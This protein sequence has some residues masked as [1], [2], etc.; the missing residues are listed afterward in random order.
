MSRPVRIGPAGSRCRLSAMR[1]LLLRIALTALLPVMGF[2]CAGI[3][4]QESAANGQQ[5]FA[6]LG[7]CKLATGQTIS[8]CRLG[9][10]T[11]GT[12]NADRSNAVLFPTWFSGTTENLA[13]LVGADKLVDPAKY[14]VI[15]VDALG[16]GVSSSPSNSAA[17]QG[18]DFP[19]F[20]TRDMVNAEYRLATEKLGLKHLHAVMGISMGGMQ[21]FEWMVNYPDFMDVAVPIVGSTRLTGYDLLLWHAEEDALKEN[22]AWH[23]GRYTKAPPMGEVE[24]IHAMN[25]RTPANYARTYPPETFAAEYAEYFSKGILPFDANDWLAQLEAMIHHDVAHGATLEDA[26]KRVKAKVL[27]VVAAQDHMVNPKPALDFAELIGAR[28]L[29]LES[30]CGHLSPGCELGKVS[31]AVRDFLDGR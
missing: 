5:Q 3:A 16:D 21:T 22:P 7:A 14:F 6:D 23:E 27:V 13:A 18:P 30:D 24:T 20:T 15:A 8:N 9:Y 2:C 19:A 12:L 11:W 25:L 31:A 29:V 17:Q 1:K 4:A 10:R 28:T 26:A